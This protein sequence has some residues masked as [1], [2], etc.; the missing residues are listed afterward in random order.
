MGPAGATYIDQRHFTI[1]TGS[2][3]QQVVEALKRYERTNGPVPVSI[4]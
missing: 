2:D 1:N 4:R 3:P